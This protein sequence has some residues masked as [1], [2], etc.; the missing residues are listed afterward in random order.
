MSGLIGVMDTDEP[1]CEKGGKE[2][3]RSTWETA[4]NLVK[5]WTVAWKVHDYF[6]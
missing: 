4:R 6:L 5:V 2:I 1:R 3:V